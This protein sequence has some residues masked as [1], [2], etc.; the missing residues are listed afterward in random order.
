M[1]AGAA[2]ATYT[3]I[4]KDFIGIEHLHGDGIEGDLE[5]FSDDLPH[6]GKNPRPG[7][8]DRRR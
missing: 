8:G 6:H 3:G 5:F 1:D 7:V 4:F 2:A